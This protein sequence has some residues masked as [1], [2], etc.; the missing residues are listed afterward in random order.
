MNLQDYR[1][2]ANS[3]IANE[4]E[5]YD[6]VPRSGHLGD[7]GFLSSAINNT[8]YGLGSVL[9]TLGTY[10]KATTGYGDTMEWAGKQF[11][12]GRQPVD[13]WD[14]NKAKD[15]PLGYVMSP[16]G[17]WGNA[18][19]LFGSSIPAL[20]ATAATKGAAVPVLAAAGM[21]ARAAGIG[22]S[23]IGAV[24]GGAVDA[25]SEAGQTYEE[26]KNRGWSDEQALSSA[27][28]TFGDNVALGAVQQ[29]IAMR[30]LKRAGGA[31]GRVLGEAE[32]RTGTE[33]LSSGQKLYN[34][35]ADFGDKNYLTRLGKGVI[36][37]GVVESYT[38]GLQNEI[39]KNALGDGPIDF[40]PMAMD[41]E[42]QDN[43]FT[44][45]TGMLPGLMVGAIGHQRGRKSTSNTN[46]EA[47]PVQEPVAA[48]P[49]PKQ[50]PAVAA[51]EAPA[52]DIESEPVSET[53]VP[54]SYTQRVLNYETNRSAYDEA[55]LNHTPMADDRAPSFSS[56]QAHANTILEDFEDRLGYN[57][58]NTST[59]V[60]VKQLS[61]DIREKYPEAK[62]SGVNIDNVAS[63]IINRGKNMQN[64]AIANQ[65]VT[66]A[67]KYGVE[68]TDA[69]KD[70]LSSTHPNIQ[71]L[72]NVAT[73]VNTAKKEEEKTDSIHNAM[74]LQYQ[75]AQQYRV[76]LSVQEENAYRNYSTSDET[77]K[78][79]QNEI[80]TKKAQ[81][82]KDAKLG[83]T[84]ERRN[85][86]TEQGNLHQGESTNERIMN[87][88]TAGMD[89]SVM[90]RSSAKQKVREIFQKLAHNEK[91]DWNTAL[92]WTKNTSEQRA[93]MRLIIDHFNARAN[94]MITNEEATKSYGK[95]AKVMRYARMMGEAT[96]DKQQKAAMDM[97]HDAGIKI[98]DYTG[99]KKLRHVKGEEGKKAKNKENNNSKENKYTESNENT[100]SISLAEE[101]KRIRDIGGKIEERI[102]MNGDQRPFLIINGKAKPYTNKAVG[103]RIKAE[104]NR[105][106]AADRAAKAKEKERLRQE[107]IKAEEE[108]KKQE[109]E[110]KKKQEEASKTT[111]TQEQQSHIQAVKELGKDKLANATEVN[112]HMQEIAK[113][114]PDLAA[115]IYKELFEKGVS[116]SKKKGGLRSK[117]A[118][119][120]LHPDWQLNLESHARKLRIDT[121]GLLKEHMH[122]LTPGN[123][124]MLLSNI[125][126][127]GGKLIGVSE[128]QLAVIKKNA[129]N[130]LKHGELLTTKAASPLHGKQKKY[131]KEQSVSYE[132]SDKSDPGIIHGKKFTAMIE[133]P[134][135][136]RDLG[137]N[138]L[139]EKLED[140][141]KGKY[142]V[143]S[144]VRDGKGHLIIQGHDIYMPG[145]IKGEVTVPKDV[146]EHLSKEEQ[147][148]FT[149]TPTKTGYHLK[150]KEL[151]RE[152]K[153][154]ATNRRGSKRRTTLSDSVQH[155]EEQQPDNV[156]V[157]AESQTDSVDNGK[158]RSTKSGSDDTAGRP[159]GTNGDTSRTV[160][161]HPDESG[162]LEER[163]GHGN[164]ERNR[165]E[166]ND[167]GGTG[168]VSEKVER[169]HDTS[170]ASGRLLLLKDKDD[171]ELDKDIADK[172]IKQSFGD[173]I[174]EKL[175]DRIIAIFNKLGT[176]II[177]DDSDV[178]KTQYK[179]A[180][181]TFDPKTNTIVIFKK[182]IDEI[183]KPTSK[184][185]RRTLLHE[186]I[187]A[188]LHNAM[189]YDK[190]TKYKDIKNS[191]IN[192]ALNWVLNKSLED[193][194]NVEDNLPHVYQSVVKF[195]DSQEGSLNT[196][197][198]HSNLKHI[199]Y[200]WTGS[201]LN[202][203]I[204]R[205][206]M[207]RSK[208]GTIYSKLN[209]Y[210]FTHPEMAQELMV[211]KVINDLAFNKSNP[212]GVL[213]SLLKLAETLHSDKLKTSYYKEI[214]QYM[215][216]H[217]IDSLDNTHTILS[218]IYNRSRTKE[219][220]EQI[221]FD[222]GV[223]TP[224]EVANHSMLGMGAKVI[225]AMKEA[226]A[227]SKNH[228]LNTLKRKLLPTKHIFEKYVP[229]AKRVYELAS[230]AHRNMIRNLMKYD[231]IHRSI[232][233][234]LSG[235][236]MRHLSNS[237]L[238][239]D[240]NHRDPLHVATIAGIHH[241]VLTHNDFIEG[242]EDTK[243]ANAKLAELKDSGQY[244]IVEK[245]YDNKSKR[246]IVIAVENKSQLYKSRAEAEK[247]V[248]DHIKEEIK[249]V[250]PG[251]NDKVAERFVLWRKEMDNAWKELVSTA[252]KY[253]KAKIPVKR[254]GFF[255][256]MHMPYVVFTKNKNS[257]GWS[258]V[259]SF[260]NASEASSYTNKLRKEGKEA[261]FVE[262]SVLD[263]YRSD[264]NAD[265]PVLTEDDLK[266]IEQDKALSADEISSVLEGQADGHKQLKAYLKGAYDK[267]HSNE[268]S[269]KTLLKIL[270][271]LKDGSKAKTQYRYTNLR[272][273]IS[274][275]K[276]GK[277]TYEDV[278]HLIDTANKHQKFSPHLLAQSDTKGY[279]LNVPEVTYRYFT[280][281]ANYTAKEKFYWDSTGI[282][283]NV[284]HKDIKDMATRE[285]EKFVK[286]YIMANMGIR[287]I[288]TLDNMIE[289][290]ITS[291]PIIGHL[292]TKYYSQHPYTDLAGNAIGMQ[293]V[294]KLG[295]FNPSSAFVQ[296]SQL[297][298][299]NA[300]L[301]GN[302]YV[303]LSKEFRQAMNAV[304]RHGK[305]TDA[306]Y[307]E[308]FDYIDL[309]T[310]N[311]GMDAE[312]LGKTPGILEKKIAGDVSFKDAMDKSMMF[313][314]WGDIKA[315]KA[316]AVA[317]YMQGINQGKTHQEAMKY[318]KDLVTET[319]FDY[320][321]VNT[322]LG[323]T[324]LGVTGKL[325][326]QFKK[327]QLFTL[328]F[329]AH[330]TKEENIRFL[331]PM[332]LLTG[333]FGLPL[334]N[335]FDDT[336]KLSG[337][338]P[339]DFM[340]RNMIE[341]AQGSNAR[342]A[343][344][345]V[346]MYGG[347]SIVG[348]NLSNRIGLGDAADMNLGPTLSTAGKILTDVRNG[349]LNK[350]TAMQ[351]GKDLSPVVGNIS[352][353][354][355]GEY[356]NSKGETVTDYSA[357]ETAMKLIGFKPLSE[358]RSTDASMLM[359]SYQ[360]KL[361][362]LTAK[363]KKAY[364]EDPSTENYEALQI[365]G[366]SDSDISKLVFEGG[367][368]PIEKLGKTVPKGNTDK[369]RELQ[370]TY[371]AMQEFS[372]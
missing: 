225:E 21:G 61:S 317:A 371:Q 108:R 331:V 311:L 93:A 210:L 67:P 300:K 42:S 160:G 186:M 190:N 334:A 197:K 323:L 120:F 193:H 122:K 44:T 357:W 283:A 37:D 202:G 217:N 216:E 92:S 292:I 345:N 302:K 277:L 141:A 10:T 209:Q 275:S 338:S 19:N 176:R 291:A 367:K 14:L 77:S 45:I 314:K 285:E 169:G 208:R 63:I 296:L 316:T 245:H 167:T 101:A 100:A 192:K 342:K 244:A 98:E 46:T 74:D 165:V 118:M 72:K 222:S 123:A 139:V 298:N 340:K 175:R 131:D 335:L 249:K 258:R 172:I 24:T 115:K 295:M 142:N 35:M 205:M 109:A 173:K 199:V 111:Y 149:A 303:G 83:I 134:H 33:A 189:L 318:A 240:E 9:D 234:G 135:E 203:F 256:H 227:S 200:K 147:G 329:L 211:S 26:A 198:L 253:A 194:V 128:E 214:E 1:N 204:Q 75:E 236:E 196:S 341:W 212:V 242:Y 155:M 226:K 360:K 247:Y 156:S 18:F 25:G 20:V 171:N 325:L 337:H 58:I 8:M 289:N 70:T 273:A 71:V 51:V 310:K 181:G 79:V 218:D 125:K 76:P 5:Y 81:V 252:S 284:F 251:A 80:K 148:N 127:N 87:G 166:Q 287:N 220:I 339:K 104:I 116:R 124:R 301:G 246:T 85:M 270:N 65:L 59:P 290:M 294:L 22:G 241:F 326:L 4:E 191:A 159:G 306:K 113:F 129:E 183:N 82:E 96:N 68:L 91:V 206:I 309:D 364:I 40:N 370:K 354:M 2:I 272:K 278:S 274:R 97:A 187:H 157:S 38:E 343:L 174:P 73:A 366:M 257:D 307:A 117:L 112:E 94:H 163:S 255:P 297:L 161:G 268:F 355:Q 271:N 78:R 352:S 320:S 54:D 312:L 372:R 223:P 363:A 207:N 221:L 43:I 359:K 286:Q 361:D 369:A 3:A 144:V 48:L 152:G 178:S 368:T 30:V 62:E 336:A 348:I 201:Y 53:P 231:K 103:R 170:P 47:E 180:F 224:D 344:V 50:E 121:H 349:G 23:V 279:S 365:Y 133:E 229:L 315:R 260:Y 333:I 119:A 330:N 263:R 265:S 84:K 235:E 351:V 52:I 254:N 269:K 49:P 213:T 356:K 308:L 228:R 13:A 88:V 36:T 31:A 17:L 28:T 110:A 95:A 64:Q 250:I 55:E 195:L 130:V 266:A 105:Q 185:P 177:Y 281:I 151:E 305:Q 11:E 264:I 350:G 16:D 150:L 32:D 107:Q 321:V 184:L 332:M 56:E 102:D 140:L 282:Y 162:R 137:N 319:N 261:R 34:A 86:G 168:S 347:P 346:A 232:F 132:R 280:D 362:E 288:S 145:A 327:Y 328:N 126:K 179:D 304:F 353:A 136:L 215:K 154:H 313:F 114:A 259:T 233:G 188:I 143:D 243:L 248:E 15:D 219:E 153:K 29:G 324:E 6:S 7:G 299:A 106:E 237:I 99:I 158:K 276:K 41:K 27:N 89:Q 358:S 230:E 182:T 322:P 138:S 12:A 39:Q 146:Y 66:E 267:T 164:S 293:N 262:M 69:Q 90:P 60:S 57:P 239:S 238:L